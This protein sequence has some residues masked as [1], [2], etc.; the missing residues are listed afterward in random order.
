MLG[1]RFVAYDGEC[2]VE[3]RRGVAHAALPPRRLATEKECQACLFTI[4]GGL[5]DR[6]ALLE[7]GDAAADIGLVL[8][9]G[10]DHLNLLAVDAP[11]KSATAMR[12][13][14]TEPGPLISA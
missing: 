9:I 1:G 13:A 14:S 12:A 5:G 7:Q 6:E 2:P 11:P 10:A 4:G 3:G 8:V